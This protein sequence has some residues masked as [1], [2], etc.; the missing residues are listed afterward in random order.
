MQ[1]SP[2]I[3][4]PECSKCEQPMAWHSVQLAGK[5]SMNVFHCESC[6]KF[7]ATAVPAVLVSGGANLKN[8]AQP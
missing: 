5:R 3:Q 8:A 2:K 1:K 4:G 7:A 6:D